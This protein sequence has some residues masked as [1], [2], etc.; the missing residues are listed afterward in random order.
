MPEGTNTLNFFKMY[1]GLPK[2]TYVLFLVQLINRIGDFV[3]P[4]LSLY[5]VSKLGFSTQTAGTIATVA[6]L[7][8]IPGSIAGGTIAD[9]WTRKGTYLIFQTLAALCILL[10]VL[11]NAKTLIVILLLF[12]TFYSAGAKPLINTMIYDSLE[13]SKR[14]LGQSLSYLGINLGVCIGPLLAGFLFN[15]YLKLFFIGDAV[16]SFAAVALVLLK[17]SDV[18]SIAIESSQKTAG[19]QHSMRE[20]IIQPKFSIFFFI[21][22]IYCFIYAQHSFSLPLMLT[23]LFED[24]GSVYFGYIMS[25]NAITVVL[26]TAW[27]TGITKKKA[28]LENISLAGI[29]YALGFGMIMFAT[30]FNIFIFSTVFW[31]IGEI[32]ISTNS[33]IYVVNQTDKNLR[34]RC[35]AFMLIISSIGKGAGIFIMGG[36]IDRYGILQVWPVIMALALA[37][38]VFTRVFHNASLKSVRS[39]SVSDA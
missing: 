26:S 30:D 12:S 37:V 2:N 36:F 31:T 19:N 15:H 16:T 18:K 35:C 25:I 28:S 1:Q 32:L 34:A 21:Y 23:H 10:C 22:L 24:K 14:R 20:I 29:F 13:P 39:K 11:A 9:H 8:Q 7:A 38:A 4:F 5:L 3:I 33:E 17:I 27:I 6:V